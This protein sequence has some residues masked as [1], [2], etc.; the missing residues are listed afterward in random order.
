MRAM[1]GLLALI[2]A[3]N[4]VQTRLGAREFRGTVPTLKDRVAE[5]FDPGGHRAGRPCLWNARL[6]AGGRGVS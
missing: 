3:S 4:A 1:A 6:R 5:H 2:S